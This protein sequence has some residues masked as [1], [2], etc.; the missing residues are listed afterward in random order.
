M[1]EQRCAYTMEP[2]DAS[3]REVGIWLQALEEARRG[4]LRTVRDLDRELLDWRGPTGLD[5]SIGTLLTHI[6]LVEMGWLYGDVLMQPELP[7]ELQALVP[8]ERGRDEDGILVPVYDDLGTHL[9]RLAAA[10]RHL[11]EQFGRMDLADWHTPRSPEDE[12]YTA[13][14]AWVAYHLVEHEAGHLFQIRS[15]K[16]QWKQ[17]QLGFPSEEATRDTSRSS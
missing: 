14:P 5:N 2:L 3:E 15:I 13:T 17:R 6:A 12:D 8:Q 1:T 9:R 16:R 10:R 4:L 7:D 11:I